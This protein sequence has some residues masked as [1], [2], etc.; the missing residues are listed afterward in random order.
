MEAWFKE[1]H[2]NGVEQSIKIDRHLCTVKSKVQEID[3][4]DSSVFG[5]VLVVDDQLMHT[6]KD[7]YIY[8]E[9]M[10]HIAMAVN[11]QIH[12]VLVVGVGDGG[13]V[14][15]LIKY[16]SIKSIKVV[17][18]DEALI[19]VVKRFMPKTAVSL[20]DPRVSIE[21]CDDMKF[22]RRVINQFDLIILDI[23]DPFGPGENYFTKEYYGNCYTALR[24]DG[25]L[26]NQHESCYYEADIPACQ[27]AHRNSRRVFE[28]SK[29][30]Q[31]S[32]PT[33]PSGHWLFGFSSK[34][35][36]PTRDLKSD[37]W[38]ARQIKTN[39]YNTNLHIGAFAL[40]TYIENILKAVE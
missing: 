1:S 14:G 32:I 37:D 11:P 28:V 31:A 30:F 38:N 40:P 35:Y 15:E 4:F 22:T 7:G 27:K 18:N 2:T 33:Y 24:D 25:I 13:I 9:M 16:D 23:P 21:V 3:V 17:E 34:K 12:D 8:H 26:I 36:H 29:V 5:R 6:E 10:V 19:T 39:Y 20:S